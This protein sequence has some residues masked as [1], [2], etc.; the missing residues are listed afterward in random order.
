MASGRYSHVVRMD[1]LEHWDLLRTLK[2]V[3]TI[4]HYVRT[5]ANLNCLKLLDTD[6]RPN[7]M[8][9]SSRR[10]LLTDERSNGIPR[11]S[12]GCKG[13]ELTNLNSA[14]SS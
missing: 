4:C 11:R 5:D 13:T 14:Q 1:S 9:S 6:G 8:F 12:D 3:R 2:S 10:M 7:G